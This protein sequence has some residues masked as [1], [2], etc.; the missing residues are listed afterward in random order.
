MKKIS[1]LKRYFSFFLFSLLLA[2]PISAMAN[3]D[4][5]EYNTPGNGTL[6]D[7]NIQFNG[8]WDKTRTDYYHG[9][10]AAASMRVD[11]TGT[12]VKINL[13]NQQGI[14]LV[15][16]IDDEAPRA[17]YAQNGT[18][19]DL[20]NLAPGRH[21]LVV[22]AGVGGSEIL[23]KGF[24][25]EQGAVTYKSKKKLLIEFI[26]DSITEGGGPDGMYTY[27]YSWQV[28]DRLGC[29]HTQIASSAIA[30][31]SGYSIFEEDRVGMDSLYFGLK[32]YRYS[33]M[34]DLDGTFV[35][36]DFTT[37]TP[38]I[39]FIF[40]GTND[41]D[42]VAWI[43]NATDEV[44]SERLD[45]FLKR[46]RGHY[47]DTHITIM[48]P[49]TKVFK[50]VIRSKVQE[51]KEAGDKKV[52][53]INS[54]G[55]L[56]AGDFSDG[57]HPNNQGTAKM[58]TNLYDILEPLVQSIKDGTDYEIPDQPEEPEQGI[59]IRFR[60]PADWPV[61]NIHAWDGQGVPLPGFET[62][63]GIPMQP[64]P[65]HEG[66]YY[67]TFD[68]SFL[69]VS[70]QFNK[71]DAD[72]L[73]VKEN[74]R[75]STNYN[76]DGSINTD[77]G[78]GEPAPSPITIRF[79]KPADWPVVYIHA[80]DDQGIPLPGFE[81][82]PG[83][84]M[85]E[86][87]HYDGWY[88]YTFD[89][90]VKK[91]S[92]QFNKGDDQD[93]IIKENVTQSTNYNSDGSVNNNIG[94]KKGITIR[95]QKPADWPVVYIHAWDDQGVPLP[96]FE[97]WPGILMQADPDYAGWYYY[98][99][100]ASVEKVSIQFNKGDDQGLIIK[101]NVTQSTN[102]NSDGSI[103]NNIRDEKG[104]T[105]RFQKPVDWP[106]V[107]IHAWGDLGI[108]LP[109]FEMWP[110]ILMQEDS[111]QAGWYY[112]TF[113]ASVERVSIQFNKGDDQD[114][115]EKENVTES[116]SYYSDGSIALSLKKVKIPSIVY[117]EEKQLV[118]ITEGTIPVEI[119]TI[120]GKTI[121]TGP[122]TGEFRYPASAG[123][124]LIRINGTTHK[125]IVR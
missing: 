20:G 74:V 21:T 113:D 118:I 8:R 91:A 35:P 66:W 14:Y 89:G 110:G 115:I 92:I 123:I 107:Y 52:H 69:S 114:M 61:V 29:D 122:A 31:C 42:G 98:T 32:N 119:Y 103:N 46:I 40:L 81:M 80:W 85:Q 112:Y 18:N 58:V 124:Y 120:M 1:A 71:G 87:P 6:T 43:Y 7:R 38:D 36:W 51:L 108:P 59:T 104:I 25:L 78:T 2:I 116:T 96:G 64:D 106:V 23:F 53:F 67:Y 105:I 37:Y 16:Q 15:I 28:S 60:K 70:F 125:L 63:P 100:D 50:N 34:P 48:N 19:L 11:F 84:R 33:Y 93:M 109:G 68:P 102:Y 4:D 111:E 24:T 45:K 5:A 47:P 22:G 97:V 30:L 99:F 17:V 12:F 10:W 9:H 117:A 26:G 79:Q 3:D 57:I 55:W 95:F 27:N 75:E 39:V 83:I 65:E 88:Y 54:T 82:W 121:Y 101:E 77:I 76:S 94:D 86:D 13:A 41:S 73:I 62:W 90:S 72:G 44:F 56:E 49:F